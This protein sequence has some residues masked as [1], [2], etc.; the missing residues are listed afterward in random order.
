MVRDNI[1]H[2]ELRNGLQH[3]GQQHFYFGSVQA[4][5]KEIPES[6]IGVKPNTVLRHLQ[7]C[8]EYT[9]PN[10]IIRKSNVI[11]KPQNK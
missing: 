11:R 4:L 3:K 5:F 6:I 8:Q 2:L 7:K 1:I 9:L 10:C